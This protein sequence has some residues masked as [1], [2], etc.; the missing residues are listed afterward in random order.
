MWKQLLDD[1]TA[2]V[3]PVTCLSCRQLLEAHE[4]HICTKC[5]I[6]LPYAQ[7]HRLEESPI[8][9]KF[10]GRIPLLY[11]WS[12]LKFKKTSRVQR[13]IHYFK[14]E[15]MPEIGYQLATHYAEKLKEEIPEKLNF[16]FI[17]PVPLHPSKKAIRGYNQ[18]EYIARGLSQVWQTPVLTQHLQRRTHSESQ[19]RKSKDARWHAVSE[20]FTLSNNEIFTHKHILLVDDVITTGATLEACASLF[21]TAKA[22]NVSVLSLAYL[23]T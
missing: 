19:T 14:Y 18:S 13:L 7:T 5:F 12:Y 3:Y 2:L 9:V 21:V 17:I 1:L 11:A 8:A 20:A 4:V 22:K 6:D 15:N 10:Y 23:E 16:D